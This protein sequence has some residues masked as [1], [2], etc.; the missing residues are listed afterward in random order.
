MSHHIVWTLERDYTQG[1]VACDDADCISRYECTQDCEVL[2]DIRRDES[3]VSHGVYDWEGEIKP[4]TR[5]EMTMGDFCNVVESLNADPSLL[6][7]LQDHPKTFEIGRTAIDVVWNGED[8]A[9][10]KRIEEEGAA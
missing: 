9:T 7:E 4:H 8:G 2:Y 6:P 5:H 10:W 3:G 1:A